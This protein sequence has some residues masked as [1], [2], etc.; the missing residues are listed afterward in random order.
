MFPCDEAAA[1]A[2]SDLEAVE[3][4]DGRPDGILR[5]ALD[6]PLRRLFDYLPP[7]SGAGR[8]V[9]GVRIRVPFGRQRLIGLV[10][11]IAASTELSPERVKS[12]LEVLDAAPVVD[13][14]AL[15]LLRW[16]ADYYHQPVGQAVAVALPKA[17]RLGAPA[18]PVEPR[19]SA[20]PAGLEAFERGEPPRA[21]QQRRVLALL[22]ERD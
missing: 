15:S 9:P 19:W 10:M 11:E 21:P 2:P 7:R 16:A 8:I 6:V 14:A 4:G 20:T 17:L 22:A 12:A 5:V 13:E 3:L 18:A 1:P